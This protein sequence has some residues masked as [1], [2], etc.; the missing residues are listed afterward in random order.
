MSDQPIVVFSTCVNA[1]D[2]IAEHIRSVS[3]QTERNIHLLTI[4]APTD[5]T[6][7]VA[8]QTVDWALETGHYGH[9]NSVT[10][11]DHRRGVVAD[12]GHQM[13]TMF[14]VIGDLPPET[15]VAWVDG[16]DWLSRPD[17]LEIIR[18]A[19]QDPDVWLTWGSF[20]YADGRPGWAGD[21]HIQT[22]IHGSFRNEVWRATH[23]KTFRAGL[24][25]RIEL[26]SLLE[27]C[28]TPNP[29]LLL[30]LVS[31]AR[32]PRWLDRAVDLAVMFPMLEMARERCAFIELP[33]YV[34]SGE[35]GGSSGPGSPTW[36][37]AQRIRDLPKY[38][39]L[40]ERPW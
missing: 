20:N 6:S 36:D 14:E 27:P 28:D 11:L 21:Y 33:L 32:L 25:Q 13:Q 35:H 29:D 7:K 2:H 39:R 10:Y 8:S 22:K 31:G 4:D 9:K 23:L 18:E 19:Y 5:L 15:I 40:N 30:A 34:Y 24:F 3:G 37:A 17:A 38:A 26:K 1:E 16:D 12:R